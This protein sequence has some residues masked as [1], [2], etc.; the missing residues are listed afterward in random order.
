[1]GRESGGRVRFQRVRLERL[2]V[3]K[4][5]FQGV[6]A[7]LFV[8]AVA[9]LVAAKISASEPRTVAKRPNILLLVAED[10]SSRVGA[11]GD[12]VARTPNLDR[13]ARQ[14]TRYSHTFTT[15]GV[16]APSR[17]ALLTGMHAISIGGQH[18]RTSSRPAGAYVAVPSD[19]VKAFPEI[20]RRAGY[21]T[22]TDAKLDYQFS[23]VSA[24]S[25]PS[26]IWDEEWAE[27]P[28]LVESD[29]Q[30]PFF[31]LINFQV[32][33][34]T[35]V[36]TPL[37]RGWPNSLMHFIVQLG[38]AWLFGIPEANQPVRSEDVEIPPYYV[39]SQ[40][41]R[42]DLARHYN[43]IYEMDRQ[44]GEI[45][46]EVEKA[47][48]S[49][50]TIVVWTTDHGDGL[51]R[52]KRELYD[53]GLRV[54]MIIRW[55]ARFRPEGSTPGMIEERLI[56]FVDLAPTILAWAGLAKPM[57]M[58]GSDFTAINSDPR[59]YVYASRDRIDEYEDRERAVR[60]HEYKYIRSW[61]PDKPTGH[62][63]AFRDNLEM[64]N[65]MWTLLEAGNLNL[66]QRLWFEPTG[67]ERLYHISTDPFELRNLADDPGHEQGVT[68]MR[69]AYEAFAE[70]VADWSEESEASM[71]ARMWPEGAQP[72]TQAPSI[73]RRS[74][75]V[76][77]RSETEGASIAYW[78]DDGKEQIYT[79]P[80]EAEPGSRITARAIRYGY[81]ESE[82]SSK[83]L[84]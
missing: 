78:I 31:G 9:L 30:T 75:R 58:Q 53:S 28:W 25:G 27:L 83:S 15:A 21:Y 71:V 64:M 81:G 32:T 41:V 84:P 24:G 7:T 3:R 57:N 19:D 70:R 47:G 18:M 68:R 79:E 55:P 60:D 4:G 65:E 37:G 77:L 40:V 39:D 8:T 16:C 42:E 45:L 52:A 73:E 72:Q 17:A 33:H 20:L 66:E 76:S 59:E 1:M 29:W 43:N 11:F 54:P 46:D 69:R 14:G 62:R 10:M 51:P 35:G 49:D 48:L 22:F 23:G 56:S 67:L 34:E 12:P 5:H 36:F 63:L 44:V 50:S 61:Y 26:T 2:K 6:S 38:R 13:L 74:G 80:F 82:E